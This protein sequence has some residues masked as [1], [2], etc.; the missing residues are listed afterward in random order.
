MAAVKAFAQRRTRG[1][2]K[3]EG[4]LSFI[5][6]FLNDTHVSSEQDLIPCTVLKTT[7]NLDKDVALMQ[8]NSKALPTGVD[9]I[10][11]LNQA[12]I[13]DDDIVVGAPV[14]T[15]GFP[16]GF[17]IGMTEQGIEANNQDG[18]VTQMR[19]DI[20][21]GHN[22][23]TTGGASGSPVFNQ[24]GQLIGIHHAGFVVTQ[25][26]NLAIKAKYAVELVK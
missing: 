26:Y 8:F 19:G 11:D 13:S 14:Y 4:V 7:N 16:A 17:G 21:F 20:E 25:G 15:I 1:E 6:C 3:V 24:Y 2:V 18:K 22:I 12:V 23:A 9:R 5:G 10:V